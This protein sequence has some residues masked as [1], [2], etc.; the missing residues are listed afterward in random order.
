MPRAAEQSAQTDAAARRSCADRL[1]G[2]DRD[3]QL[4]V[5]ADLEPRSFEEVDGILE[6][7]DRHRLSAWRLSS[8]HDHGVAFNSED[9]IRLSG[10]QRRDFPTDQAPE[11]RV[12]PSASVAER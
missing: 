10:G 4:V 6:Q 8:A 5:R 11:M 1:S 12:H 9:P 7:L 3:T 2:P